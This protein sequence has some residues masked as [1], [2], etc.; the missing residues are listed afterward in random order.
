MK[1]FIQEIKNKNYI[2]NSI[3]EIISLSKKIVY[4]D[5]EKDNNIN[6][7]K[8]DIQDMESKILK[9]QEKIQRRKT[10]SISP[11]DKSLKKKSSKN[12]KEIK[13]PKKSFS[14]NIHSINIEDRIFETS[15]NL[16]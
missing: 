9:L 8:K 16:I 4:I 10:S 1:K 12:S 14:E 3:D 11:N 15:C 13:T 5:E 7:T 2:Q 6:F